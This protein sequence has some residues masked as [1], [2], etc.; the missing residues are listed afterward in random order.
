MAGSINNDIEVS[1][2]VT[3]SDSDSSTKST[4]LVSCDCDELVVVVSV[5][6]LFY[7]LLRSDLVFDRG[8]TSCHMLGTLWVC[9]VSHSSH[10]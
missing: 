7:I 3:D 2:E 9:V 8:H 1:S 5:V 10:I 4:F 6:V